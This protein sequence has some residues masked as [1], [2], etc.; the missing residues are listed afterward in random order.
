MNSGV[1]SS[2]PAWTSIDFFVITFRPLMSSIKPLD[3]YRRKKALRG[4]DGGHLT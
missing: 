3:R 4:T 2:F 1:H